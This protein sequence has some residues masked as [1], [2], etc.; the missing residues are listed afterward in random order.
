MKV[1]T[2]NVEFNVTNGQYDPFWGSVTEGQWEPKTFKV[3]K[4]YLTRNHSYVDIGAWIGPTVLFA[5]KLARRV[6]AFEP[7]PVAFKMLKDNLELN[8]EIDERVSAMP[9]AISDRTGVAKLGVHSELGDSMSSFLWVKDAQDVDTISLAEIFNVFDRYGIKDCSLIKIDVEGGEATLLPGA[10]NFLNQFPITL[11]L[12][13]HTPW[14]ADKVEYF[15]KICPVLALYKNLYNEKN[16]RISIDD[17]RNL[18]G[19]TTVVATNY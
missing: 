14:F 6:Y 10:Y 13:L 4:R 2:N 15:N 8:P 1:Q 16:E 3:L 11:F 9:V 12:S 7:D 17:V 18:E 19:F 5:G